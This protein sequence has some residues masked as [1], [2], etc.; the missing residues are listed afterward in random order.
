MTT[1]Y[2]RSGRESPRRR[3]SPKSR[4]SVPRP[5]C[6]APVLRSR[7]STIWP[8]CAADMSRAAGPGPSRSSRR[9]ASRRNRCADR[10]GPTRVPCRPTTLG[11]D[12]PAPP[13]PRHRRVGGRERGVEAVTRRLHDSTAVGL[14]R[15][16]EQGVVGASAAFMVSGCRSQSAVEPSTSVNRNVTVPLG[17]P[18]MAPPSLETTAHPK[19]TNGLAPRG[20]CC[21]L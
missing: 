14:D 19:A 9:H 11:R 3:C 10:S 13:P 6:R 16:P 15:M 8:P 1:W 5:R 18:G 4:N 7:V 17:S 2:T 20:W 21:S 12:R